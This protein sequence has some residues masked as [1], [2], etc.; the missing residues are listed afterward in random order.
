[1]KTIEAK[2]LVC[3]FIS[4]VVANDRSHGEVNIKCI[5]EECM[6][7]VSKTEPKGTGYCQRLGDK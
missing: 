1:M 2:Q 4:G 7:W 5:A 3:P 6:A